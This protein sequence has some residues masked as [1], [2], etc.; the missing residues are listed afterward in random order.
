M[1]E[2]REILEGDDAGQ[3]QRGALR[4]R[5]IPSSIAPERSVFL[6][7]D[8]PQIRLCYKDAAGQVFKIRMQAV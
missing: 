3:W 5:P 7:T 4:F 6:N 1:A 2:L 8:M